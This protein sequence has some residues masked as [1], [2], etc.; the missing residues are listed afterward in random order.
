MQTQQQL[1]NL[2]CKAVDVSRYYE[3]ITAME[4]L[5]NADLS[6]V[7]YYHMNLAAN[8]SYLDTELCRLHAQAMDSSL[9]ILDERNYKISF[10]EAEVIC[11]A[12]SDQ[13]M[14]PE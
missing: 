6:G 9:R 3:M 4:G 8:A 2:M 10:R 7:W 14:D 12:F 1:Y 5:S 11:A 13:I